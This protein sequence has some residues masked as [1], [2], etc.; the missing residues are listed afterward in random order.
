MK[1]LLLLL[2]ACPRT[3]SVE[4]DVDYAFARTADGAL[5]V[6]LDAPGDPSGTT[7]LSFGEPWG[8][9]EHPE[10]GVR[11]VMVDGKPISPTG[12]K[13][14]AHTGKR[15]H[16]VYEL[17]PTPEPTKQGS[18]PFHRPVVSPHL[19][20]LIG[21]TGILR[22]EHLANA[23]HAVTFRW[24][25]PGWR[26]VSSYG[27]GEVTHAAGTLDELRDAVFLASDHLDL[28]RI[29]IG[30]T[31]LDVAAVNDF[32]FTDEQ[33]AAKAEAV[34]KAQRGFF[35]EEGPPFFLI[36]AIPLGPKGMQYGGTGLTNSFAIFL[37]PQFTDLASV[38]WLLGHELFHSWNGRVIQPDAPEELMYWFSEGFTNFYAR[39]LLY[40]A[41]LVDL[42]GYVANLN[43][44]IQEY[45]LSP[46]R[47]APNQAIKDGFWKSHELERLP[48][49][50]G[51]V[52]ALMIDRQLPDGLDPLMKALVAEGRAGKTISID[53]LF[54]RIPTAFKPTVVDGTMMPISSPLLFPCLAL[55]SKKV[56]KF[57]LGF[58]IQ[59]SQTAKAIVGLVPGSAAE[60]AG[61]REG[62]VVQGWSI[63][64]NKPEVPVE[65]TTG[66]KHI[67]YLPQGAPV[68]V[69]RFKVH[70]AAACPKLL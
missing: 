20:H 29:A 13:W 33:L 12:G 11:S 64:F 52:L 2:A 70:D 28:K 63:Y 24:Q 51:D 1:W 66:G 27:D 65:V 48:Y 47:D 23:K 49:Q 18:E 15:M 21:T 55:D 35:E 46:V 37:A 10:T 17:A 59:A 69:P 40:R 60:R 43:D 26:G 45:W 62:D 31:V 19:V 34:V 44:E 3:P 25:M 50:R 6:T 5:A 56:G 4:N 38:T 58:D 7:T 53:K 30:K 68:D 39:R 61:L 9:I 14:V 36:T 67:S 16:V 54:K 32:G 57:E 42:D 8:G 41:G 22:P